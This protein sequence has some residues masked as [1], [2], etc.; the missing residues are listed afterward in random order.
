MGVEIG[1]RAQE[2]RFSDAGRTGQAY[3]F[4]RLDR[5]MIRPS[6]TEA[7]RFDAQTA[8]NDFPLINTTATTI[9]RRRSLFYILQD[10]ARG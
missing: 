4:T 1:N 2:Q 6:I 9:L 3:A 5:E 7:K 8:Q 10:F